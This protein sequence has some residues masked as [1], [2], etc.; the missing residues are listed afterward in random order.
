MRGRKAGRI[1]G[2]S[3]R[4][5]AQRKAAPHRKPL[6]ETGI[7]IAQ[8]EFGEMA[9]AVKR[10]TGGMVPEARLPASVLRAEVFEAPADGIRSAG[11]LKCP[12][13]RETL[14]HSL[15][16]SSGGG[17]V[18]IEAYESS[19]RPCE[20]LREAIEQREFTQGQNGVSTLPRIQQYG[21]LVGREQPAGFQT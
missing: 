8:D 6:A 17:N 5:P 20:S 13:E 9:A 14:L 2:H 7:E 10:K 4:K 3:R 12:A 11:F 15:F 19:E 16:F 21:N 1:S 18:R